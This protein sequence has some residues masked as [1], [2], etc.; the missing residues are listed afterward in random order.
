MRLLLLLSAL[1][2]G[3]TGLIAGQPASARAPAAIAAALSGSIE[4]AKDPA[5]VQRLPEAS[6]GPARL[7]RHA[8]A[9]LRSIAPQ[10]HAVDERR[11]E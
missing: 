10:S 2:A 9:R 4:Q 8:E 1:I 3:L 6:A 7:K 5:E 11:I